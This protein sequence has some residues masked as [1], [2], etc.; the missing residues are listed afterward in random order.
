MQIHKDTEKK[1]IRQRV[2][3][4][5]SIL[6]LIWLSAFSLLYGMRFRTGIILS[7]RR[8]GHKKRRLQNPMVATRQYYVP[9]KIFLQPYSRT[10]HSSISCQ[11]SV[12]ATIA[13]EKEWQCLPFVMQQQRLISNILVCG[14]GDLSYSAFIAP[15]LHK[16]GIKMTATVLETKEIHTRI[17]SQSDFNKNIVESFGHTVH[18]GIDATNLQAYDPIKSY[19]CVQFN[20]PHCP[21]KSN[22]RRN[23]LLLQAF[24]SS[25]SIVISEPHGEIHVALFANQGGL[26]QQNFSQ[27][28]SSW[29]SAQYGAECGLLLASVTPFMSPYKRSSY[30]GQ[31][32]SF[33]YDKNN[34]NPPELYKFIRGPC[35]LPIPQHLQLCFRHELHVLIPLDKYNNNSTTFL[36]DQGEILRSEI[37]DTLPDGVVVDVPRTWIILQHSPSSDKD[38]RLVCCC[39]LVVYRGERRTVTRCEAD[40]F[41]DRAEQVAKQSF[42]LRENRIGKSVS[43]PF[44][45]CT[46]Q[47]IINEKEQA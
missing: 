44:P 28:K 13:N 43:R 34:N 9:T 4:I 33:H 36:V 11:L 21:G 25:S 41:R 42:R 31:D 29:L 40:S 26:Q 1:T 14:D 46:L 18:F 20:F 15:T 27:W 35:C 45:Y 39:F 22:I 32:K 2:M 30:R 38:E 8:V 7:S 6:L 37:Q 12:A 47:S 5:Y 24:L 10:S 3:Y 16:L 19:D 17:Y 23:R